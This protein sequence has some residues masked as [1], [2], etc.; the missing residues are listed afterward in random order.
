MKLK[1]KKKNFFFEGLAGF[2]LSYQDPNPMSKVDQV[3]LWVGNVLI[4]P[5]LGNSEKKV[6][7]KG[8]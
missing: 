1:R 7:L 6:L 8:F 3:T 5:E 2:T 4:S